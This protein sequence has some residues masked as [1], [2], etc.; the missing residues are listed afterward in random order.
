M[1]EKE[2]ILTPEEYKKVCAL[3]AILFASCT[4]EEQSEQMLRIIK[5][6]KMK[7]KKLCVQPTTATHSHNKK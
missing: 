5:S 6:R 4:N 3:D 7:N 2:M 1:K